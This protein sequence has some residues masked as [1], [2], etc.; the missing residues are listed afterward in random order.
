MPEFEETIITEYLTVSGDKRDVLVV[1]GGD[2][3]AL[4]HVEILTPAQAW[5]MGRML[6]TYALKAGYQATRGER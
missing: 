3:Y 6:R 1:C 2:D 4:E 5:K